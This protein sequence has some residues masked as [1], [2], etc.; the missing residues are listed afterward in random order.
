[1]RRPKPSRSD[2]V[3]CSRCGYPVAWSHRHTAGKKW[4]SAYQIFR[5][6]SWLARLAEAGDPRAI[7][8]VPG[9]E[10]YEIRKPKAAPY[11]PTDLASLI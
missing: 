5:Y 3:Q 8:L 1:M 7:K 11:V 6:L 9:E 2:F 10:R 4:L